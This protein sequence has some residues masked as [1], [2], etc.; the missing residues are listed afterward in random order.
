[1][2]AAVASGL[3]DMVSTDHAP[4]L[5]REKQEGSNDIFKAPSGTPGVETRL[6]FDEAQLLLRGH[7]IDAARGQEDNLGPIACRQLRQAGKMLTQHKCG[8]HQAVLQHRQNQSAAAKM[9]RGFGQDCL[10]SQ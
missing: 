6:A 9:K 3:I 4:H 10:T 2:T 7:G 8:P 1:M 5:K